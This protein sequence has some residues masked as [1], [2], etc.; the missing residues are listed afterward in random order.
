M[1]MPVPLV[2]AHESHPESAPHV[3][4]GH[5]GSDYADPV[6][7]RRV[8]VSRAEN[9]VLAE[10]AGGA[11]EAGDRKRRAHQRP[12]RPRR[13][14]P[15]TAHMPHVLLAVA[16]MDYAARAEEQQRLEERM[17]HDVPD[18]GGERAHANTEEHVSKLR[19]RRV[20]VDLLDIGLQEADGRGEDGGGE[21]DNGHRFHGGGRMREDRGRAH[22]HVDA[23]GNHGRGVDESG[24][25]RGTF[26]RIGQPHVERNLRRLS[27]SANKKQQRDRGECCRRLA[28]R[29]GEYL[30]EIERSEIHHDQE[31]GERESEVADA[32]HD[33]GFVAGVRGALLDEVETHQ[34]IAAQPDA[35]PAHEEDQIIRGQNQGQHEEH[36]QVHVG[37]EAVIAFFVR[38][39]AGGVDVNQRPDARDD[40]EHD[41]RQLVDRKIPADLKCPAPDPREVVFGVPELCPD[42]RLSG[43]PSGPSRTT[44]R[45]SAPR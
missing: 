10:V 9:G 20:S 4:R 27:T 41:H 24:D 5:A 43:T 22:A 23:R 37:E 44:P 14:F 2:I 3:E 32:I 29:G 16:G 1:R 30:R 38:H 25:R 42:R 33:E 12:H 31:H 17:R 7:P 45:R 19:D 39:V 26:H 8:T 11:R 40:H 36:E 18:A 13:V 21:A 35:F 15:Q 6:H 34:Q 28:G